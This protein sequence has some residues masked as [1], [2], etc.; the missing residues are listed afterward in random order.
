MKAK[1]CMA[2]MAVFAFVIPGFVSAELLCVKKT[3]KASKTGKVAL[4]KSLT[5]AEGACPKG[6]SVVLDLAG[7]QVRGL[8]GEKGEPGERGPAGPQGPQGAPGPQGPAGV[9]GMVN[10]DSCVEESIAGDSCPPD[11]VCETELRCG[12][13]NAKNGSA[14]GDYMIAWSWSS[15]NGAAYV[16]SNAFW[17]WGSKPQG[18][19]TGVT[20]R[21]ASEFGYSAH[22]PVLRIV[23]CSP[24]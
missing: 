21:T 18:Y 2:C 11:Y 7:I 16:T 15:D 8:P 9:P 3:V 10:L 19:P 12:D 1:W 5:T 24:S 14:L 6:H 20:I 17:M 4:S 22:T 13:G 23:C